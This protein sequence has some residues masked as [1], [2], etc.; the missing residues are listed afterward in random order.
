MHDEIEVRV[1]HAPWRDACVVIA[2]TAASA[3]ACSIWNVSELLRRW[4]A[5]W[6]RFQLDELP[7]VLIVLASGLAWFAWRRFRESR[8]EIERRQVIEDRLRGALGDNRRL[9]Q[10]YVALQET[11]RRELARELHDELGQALLVI[12]MD[13][14]GIRA[15]E[16]AM[17]RAASIIESSARIQGVIGDMLRQLRPVGLDQ[18]GLVPALE[19]Y[20]A[21]WR[22]RLPDTRIGLDVADDLGEVPEACAI[23][24][25]RLVQE[26]MTNAA[27]H[28]AAS[29]ISVTLN[30]ATRPDGST[31]LV[32][33]VEDDG[34]GT[35]LTMN[36]HGL[37]LIGM[38]ERVEAL[39]GEFAIVSARGEGF[40]VTASL[41]MA[42]PPGAVTDRE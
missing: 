17:E 3:V 2:L 1:P 9:A 36:H 16:P 29:R 22:G 23:S 39:G 26:A 13:A 32:V 38:R 14:S 25:F 19:H 20:V 18:L 11:E 31:C 12:R 40:R 35:A 7:A 34:V 6:E 15:G 41:P 42:A 28:A 5:P 30:P 21:Q 37:G 4:T 33:S 24:A 27:K 8:F 10:R